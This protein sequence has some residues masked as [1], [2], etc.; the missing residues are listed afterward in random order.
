M[1]KQE[2]ILQKGI[3]KEV[4][5]NAMFRIILLDKNDQPIEK[6]QEILGYAAGKLRKFKIKIIKGDKVQ[7]EMSPYDLQK[8]RVTYRLD[9]RI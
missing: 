9:K 5:P 1:A 2:P 8:A 3:I 4:L 6:A 7:L